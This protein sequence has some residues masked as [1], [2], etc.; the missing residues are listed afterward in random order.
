MPIP[1][2]FLVNLAATV[3]SRHRI[4]LASLARCAEAMPQQFN[5]SA[6][7]LAPLLLQASQD[8]GSF[9][10]RRFAITCLSYLRVIT[11]AVLAALLRLAGDTHTVQKDTLAAAARFNRLDRSL[12]EALPSELTAALAG[13]S[14][15]RARTA[16]R[17][18]Q[19]LGTSP[20][21][22]ATPG[23]R[24]QIVQALAAALQDPGSR[25]PVWTSTE[26]T[27]RTLDQDLYQALLKVAGF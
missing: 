27:D 20:A 8:A 23:L 13:P 9:N 15:L 26:N 21:A 5:R 24:R 17:L 22:Q 19:A 6:A 12:G 14:V 11:P 10:S 7:D 3:W 16:V 18:L 25:R 1:Q 4:A 2:D